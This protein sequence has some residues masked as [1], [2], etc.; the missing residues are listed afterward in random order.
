MERL[1][2]AFLPWVEAQRWVLRRGGQ[3]EGWDGMKVPIAWSPSHGWHCPCGAW[4]ELGARPSLLFSAS[5]AAAFA[6]PLQTVAQTP[7]QAARLNCLIGIK[8]CLNS[9]SGDGLGGSSPCRLRGHLAWLA[10]ARLQFIFLSLLRGA[11]RHT[12]NT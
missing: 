12:R 9:K 6:L 11:L 3:A 1:L 5:L 10:S 8:K 7:F 2:S 4:M